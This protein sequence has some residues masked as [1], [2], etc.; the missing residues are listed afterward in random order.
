[1]VLADSKPRKLERIKGQAF[2]PFLPLTD[3]DQRNR[4]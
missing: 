4:R 2:V 3:S 1:M